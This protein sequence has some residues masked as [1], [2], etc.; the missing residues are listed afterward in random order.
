[1]R[2]WNLTKSHDEAYDG[3][4]NELLFLY[5]L[6]IIPFSMPM[7][8]IGENEKYLIPSHTYVYELYELSYVIMKLHMKPQLPPYTTDFIQ[9]HCII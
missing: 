9:F 7:K 8:Y 3:E 4:K 2:F 1:M 5:F 6:A